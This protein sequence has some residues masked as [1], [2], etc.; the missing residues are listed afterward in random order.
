ML[1]LGDKEEELTTFA[2]LG[3]K[4][5]DTVGLPSLMEFDDVWVV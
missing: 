3:H 2:K 4:E 1:S 5:T